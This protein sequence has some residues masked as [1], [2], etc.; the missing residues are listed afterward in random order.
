MAEHLL[1]LP[2]KRVYFNAIKGGDKVYEYRLATDYW[3]KRLVGRD[4]DSIE[5]TM[6]YPSASDTARR[7]YRPWRGYRIE[8][9]THEHFGAQ[10]VEVFSIVVNEAAT[11]A[12][13][14]ETR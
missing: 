8:T 11:R 5:L 12:A 3:R 7:I 13:M 9:I 6:G 10:P 1:R 14:K 4:Y 2:L